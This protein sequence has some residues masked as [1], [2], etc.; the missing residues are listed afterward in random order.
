[1]IEKNEISYTGPAK[2]LSRQQ[3]LLGTKPETE[4]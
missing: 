1:M 3:E 2:C 4:I